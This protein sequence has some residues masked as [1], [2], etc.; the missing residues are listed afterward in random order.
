[1]SDM[2]L[3]L[4]VLYLKKKTFILLFSLASEMDTTIIVFDH[5][6]LDIYLAT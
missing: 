4:K 2:L 6:P 3:H 1:M 5:S